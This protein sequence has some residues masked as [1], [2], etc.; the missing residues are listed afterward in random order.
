VVE[1]GLV[2]EVNRPSI[3][4]LL[5]GEAFALLCLGLEI[6]GLLRADKRRCR[7][8]TADMDIVS[9]QGTI[10]SST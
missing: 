7:R 8:K 5:C 10:N 3:A 9:Q 6:Y 4:R 1:K 2:L